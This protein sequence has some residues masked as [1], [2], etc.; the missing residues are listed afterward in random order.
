MR[1]YLDENLSP[2]IAEIGRRQGL[3]ITSWRDSGLAGRTD[4]E[5][6]EFAAAEGRC[7]VTQ[8]FRDFRALNRRWKGADRPHAGILYLKANFPV[9][10]F[11][12]VVTALTRFSREHPDG[13]EPYTVSR[14]LRPER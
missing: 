9:T 7:L 6:L 2:R 3:D 5:H 1:F 14:L 8:D 10:N 11:R 12:A 13:P 4:V